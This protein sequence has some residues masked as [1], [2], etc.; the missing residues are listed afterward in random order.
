MIERTLI[1]AAYIG[2]S[3]HEVA[4]LRLPNPFRTACIRAELRI[5]IVSDVPGSS[6][7]RVRSR[8]GQY[9]IHPRGGVV[10]YYGKGPVWDKNS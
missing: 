4:L 10:R 3:R 5:A 9:H 8:Q 7:A 2:L 6:L 1:E